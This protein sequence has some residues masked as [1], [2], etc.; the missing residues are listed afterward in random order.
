MD[1]QTL[2][3]LLVERVE[4]KR[5]DFKESFHWLLSANAARAAIVKDILGM[6]NTAAGGALIFGVRDNSF[7]PV[8]MSEDETTSFEQTRVNDFLEHYTDPR[9]ACLVEKFVVEGRRF[10]VLEVPEFTEIPI[11]CGADANK[12]DGSSVLCHGHVYIRTDAARTVAINSSEDMRELIERA[13]T[14]TG[15]RL[16]K[17]FADLLNPGCRKESGWRLMGRLYAPV[18]GLPRPGTFGACAPCTALSH[19]RVRPL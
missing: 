8:G 12:P 5:F 2:E 3:R 6:A 10:V 14:K 11:I 16:M 18:L 19:N 13:V 17:N 4:S 7:E 15:Q 9:H 1:Q